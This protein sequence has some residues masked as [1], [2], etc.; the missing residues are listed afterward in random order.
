MST[1][2]NEEQELREEARYWQRECKK[3]R[4]KMKEARARA[5]AI[6]RPVVE[7]VRGETWWRIVV[8]G[9]VIDGYEEESVAQEPQ[10]PRE[11]RVLAHLRT[12]QTA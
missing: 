5:D 9:V 12:P 10:A 6:A 1:S 7:V 2:T 11:P 8:N 4:A 3:A